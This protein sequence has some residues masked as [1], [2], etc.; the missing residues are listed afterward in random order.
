MPDRVLLVEG[1]ELLGF[2]FELALVDAGYVVARARNGWDALSKLAEGA[3]PVDAVITDV[4]FRDGPDGWQVARRARAR[5]DGLPVIYMT[6]A[7]PM[8]GRRST[9]LWA[10][11]CSALPGQSAGADG[12]RDDRPPAAKA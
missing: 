7:G 2:L 1:D 3:P 6:G 5:C 4:D 9:C 12:G 11:C 10:C 8:N